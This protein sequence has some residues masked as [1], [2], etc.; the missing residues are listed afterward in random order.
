MIKKGS[1]YFSL[2]L[3]TVLIFSCSEKSL[4]ELSGYDIEKL[5]IPRLVIAHYIE[6]G[7]MVRVS[8]FRS[9]Y[10]ADYS[11]DFESCRN[12]K[13]AFEPRHDFDW[14]TIMIHSP[15]NGSIM[16]IIDEATGSRIIIQSLDYPD[17]EIILF[18]VRPVQSLGIAADVSAGQQIGTHWGSE[19]LPEI[20]VWVNTTKGRKLIS[21]FE[22]MDDL[23]L[24]EYDRCGAPAR[25]QFIITREQRDGDPLTCE[26]M[27]FTSAGNLDNWTD[28]NCRYDVDAWGI[29]KMVTVHYLEFN[30]LWRI[31]RFRS[32]VGHSY[33]DDFEDCRSMKHYFQPQGDTGWETV[34]IFAPVTGTLVKMWDEWLGTQLW[35][36]S[37]THPDFEFGIFHIQ[38]QDTLQVGQTLHA[39]QLLGTHISS[40]TYSDIAVVVWT[41]RGRKL[42]SYFDTLTDSLFQDYQARGLSGRSELIISKEERNANPL[43]CQGESFLSTADPLPKWV[44]LQ[45]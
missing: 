19:A 8:Q 9:A 2:I 25:E 35:I 5:G 37:Q 44:Y 4:T 3:I 11:D 17:F 31:S 34:K 10:G 26:E 22:V 12:M 30:R 41:P 6:P 40:K 33:R 16:D 14:S 39:G 18:N 23:L 29:P 42:I 45:W 20:A 43:S 38:L 36:Q 15:V 28:L 32:S 7:R 24:S 27:V 1:P 21:Y 13:H